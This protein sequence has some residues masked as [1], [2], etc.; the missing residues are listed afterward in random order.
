[1]GVIRRSE[2]PPYLLINSRRALG[3]VLTDPNPPPPHASPQASGFLNL[4]QA[5]VPTCNVHEIS[6]QFFPECY[7]IARKNFEPFP[8]AKLV[9]GK[10]P[11]T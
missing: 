9:R 7:E 4:S 6:K 10:V 3:L 11:D 2:R 5:N 8:R 1:M